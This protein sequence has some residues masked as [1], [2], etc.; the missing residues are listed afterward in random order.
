MKAC[1]FLIRMIIRGK[2]TYCITALRI[3]HYEALGEDM[4]PQHLMV[5]IV[6]ISY[7]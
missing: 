2:P 7:R 3:T 6:V 5:Q 4:K 1:S